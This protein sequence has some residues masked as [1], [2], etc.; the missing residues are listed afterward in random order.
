MSTFHFRFFLFPPSWNLLSKVKSLI[1]SFM[2][3]AS[4]WILQHLLMR[5]PKHQADNENSMVVAPA[6]SW[7]LVLILAQR[8]PGVCMGFPWILR[9]LH[10]VQNHAGRC[11]SYSLHWIAHMRERACAW[12]W[13]PIQGEFPNVPG[14]SSGYTTSLNEWTSAWIIRGSPVLLF[15]YCSRIEK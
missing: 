14:I 15:L 4:V 7:V 12:W 11:V 1:Y 5:T 6:L 13:R 3:A 8:S 9:F 2:S 10:A